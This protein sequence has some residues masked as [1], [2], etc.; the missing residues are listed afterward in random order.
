MHLSERGYE[1]RRRGSRYSQGLGHAF[2]E[3]LAPLGLSDAA[4]WACFDTVFAAVILRVASGP[5]SR[6]RIRRTRTRS[7]PASATSPCTT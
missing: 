6:P 3:L 4:A 5:A 1:V 2:V 7:S